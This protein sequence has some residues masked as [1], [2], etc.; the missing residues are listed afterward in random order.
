MEIDF[1]EYM[2]KLDK[3]LNSLDE[4]LIEFVSVLD[5]E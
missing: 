4:F 1:S 2:I 3:E 5:D